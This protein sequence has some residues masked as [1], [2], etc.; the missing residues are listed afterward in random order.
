MDL[1]KRRKHFDPRRADIVVSGAVILEAVLKRLKVEAVTAVDRG[2]RDG[3]LQDLL[4]RR[5]VDDRDQSLRDAALTVQARFGAPEAHAAQV[6]KLALALFDDLAPVH[7][8][9]ASARPWLE[10]AALLHDI[11]NA[12]NYQ[13]HHKHSQY[14]IENADLPGLSD[15]EKL[16]IG[17]IARFHRRSPPEVGHEGMAG[18]TAGESRLVRKCATLLRVAD[19][20]DRSHRQPIVSFSAAAKGRSVLIK[21]RSKTPIDLE[22]WDVEH[23][24]KLFREVFG[25]TLVFQNTRVRG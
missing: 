11:G 10:V 16:L 1:E 4:R 18:L 2:L 21:L 24:K 3:L 15:R 12:V 20:F 17:R 13:R 25:R 6:S 22:L 7:Q 8:L 19:S 5:K 9:P 23:E 14:L